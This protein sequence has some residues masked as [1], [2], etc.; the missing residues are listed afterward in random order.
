MEASVLII[1]YLWVFPISGLKLIK[2]QPDEK[3]NVGQIFMNWGNIDLKKTITYAESHDQALV[4]DKTIIFRLIDKDM[5]FSMSKFTPN[6][7]VD[8]GIAIHKMIRLITI[9]NKSWRLS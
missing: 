5:Y 7:V 4:G 3:W 1:D 9:S 6:I 2:E 8:R